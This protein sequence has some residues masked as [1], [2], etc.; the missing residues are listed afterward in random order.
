FTEKD[1]TGANEIFQTLPNNIGVSSVVITGPLKPTGPGDTPSRR[2]IFTCRPETPAQEVP[3][4]KE[5]LTALATRAYRRAATNSDVEKLLGFYQRGRNDG[6]NFDFGI[7]M[8][9]SRV[10]VGSDFVFRFEKE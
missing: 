10:L 6:G 5:I 9:L 2:K 3:C 8:A 4:A 1:H 7:E